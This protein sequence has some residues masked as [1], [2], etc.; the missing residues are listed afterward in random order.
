MKPLYPPCSLRKLQHESGL[1]LNSTIQAYFF[2]FIC[3]L[4]FNSQDDLQT[5][6]AVLPT[7]I[8]HSSLLV[9]SMQ[10]CIRYTVQL[11]QY[12][13]VLKKA[14]SRNRTW[15]RRNRSQLP[16]QKTKSSCLLGERRVRGVL[17][18]VVLQSCPVYSMTGSTGS[19]TASTKNSCVLCAYDTGE[20]YYQQY[21]YSCVLCAV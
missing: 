10:F 2:L 17:L 14:V 13:A 15:N 16:Y 7:A 9:L 8:W 11:G 19:P 4:L 21:Q 3:C 5:L 12:K 20:S 6:E 1:N 18:F